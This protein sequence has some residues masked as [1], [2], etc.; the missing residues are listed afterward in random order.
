MRGPLLSV[1]LLFALLPSEIHADLGTV[2]AQAGRLET[3]GAFREADR[4]LEEAVLDDALPASA[5]QKIEFERE[6]LRRIRRDFRLTREEVWEGL[7]AAMD[8]VTEEEFSGWI[9]DG[10]FDIR[11]IDGEERFFS[12]SVSNLF[13]R[14]PELNSRRRP[15]R[16]TANRELAYVE[17]AAAIRSAGL[18]ERRSRVLPKRFEVQMEVRLKPGA[19]RAGEKVSAWLPMP[20]LM[21][22]QRDIRWL[23]S[24]PRHALLAAPESPIRSAYLESEATTEGTTTFRIEYLYTRDGLWFDLTPEAVGASDTNHVELRQFVSESPHIL[25]TPEMRRL[26]SEIADG[27]RNPVRRARRFYDWIASHVRYS[28]AP[29]YST[30]RDLAEFCRSGRRGDCGQAAFLFMTLCRI[31]AI[32]ARWESGWAIFPGSETIHDW[33]EIYLPPWGWVPVD[34]YMGMYAI[35]YTPSLTSS[36]RVD[37]KDFYFGGMD[38]YRMTANRDHSQSLTPPKRTMRSD[39]VDFQRGEVETPGGNLFFDRFNYDLTWKEVP[40]DTELP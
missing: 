2:L 24:D 6:R 23:R 19:A 33:C 20:C 14:R 27:E 30:I 13:F 5:R 17:N 25:F 16:D 21:S 22:H 4:A 9:R 31:S 18:R 36:Q 38:Q 26:A 34:P 11:V 3:A 12:S 35:Q 39:D 7:R 8:G 40:V 15:R 37:L 28:Y 1:V 29:E 10:L 32:P